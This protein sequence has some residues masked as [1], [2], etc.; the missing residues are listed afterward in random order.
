MSIQRPFKRTARPFAKDKIEQ[1]GLWRYI[2]HKDFA[3]SPEHYVRAYLIIQKD[4]LNLLDYIEPSDTNLK[5][6]SFRIHELLLRICIEIEANCV[7]ILSENGYIKSGNWTMDDYKKINKSHKLSSFEVKLPVWKGVDNIRRP[8]ENW[9]DHKSLDWWEGY[10][11]SKHDRHTEFE[12]ATFKNLTEAMCGLITILSA[13]FEDNDFSSEGF[14]I[15]MFGNSDGMKS[16]IGGY[17]RIKYPLDW[18]EDKKYDFK[19]SDIENE[20]N[21]MGKYKYE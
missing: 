11:K 18:T 3:N 5:T 7:A 14:G 10:N 9:K 1:G 12:R 2:L 15:G 20:P 16:A 13:Q 6:Y 19:W 4:F 17:F 8:F 21:P